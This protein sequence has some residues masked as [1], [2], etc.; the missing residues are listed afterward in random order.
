M[1]I[2][3]ALRLLARDP[4]LFAYWMSTESAEDVMLRKAVL[5]KAGADPS[6]AAVR[7][8]IAVLAVRYPYRHR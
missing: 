6:P 4:A 2:K 1:R 8:A 7:K 3:S 5:A